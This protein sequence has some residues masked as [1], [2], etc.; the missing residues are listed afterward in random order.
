[1]IL[2]FWTPKARS[3]RQAAINY[4]A[5]DNPLAALDQLDQIEYQT[6]Y[7]AERPKMG[8]LGRVRGTRELVISGTPFIAVYR[9]KGSRIEI[10]CFLHGAQKWPTELSGA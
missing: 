1:M 5:K 6:S 7:L 10:L 4:I 8:R 3:E 9:F 2:I